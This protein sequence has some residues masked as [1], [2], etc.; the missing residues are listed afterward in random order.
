MTDTTALFP[1]KQCNAMGKIMGWESDRPGCV[2]RCCPHLFQ[3]LQEVPDKVSVFSSMKQE[4]ASLG[5]FLY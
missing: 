4:N 2:S 1:E 5:Y 3:D